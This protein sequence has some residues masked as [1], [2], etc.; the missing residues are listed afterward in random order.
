MCNLFET[1]TTMNIM[2]A[3]HEVEALKRLIK[4]LDSYYEHDAEFDNNTEDWALKD[5]DAQREIAVDIANILR[6][7]L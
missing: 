2:F 3:K 6:E 7:K 5:L 1:E 4:G